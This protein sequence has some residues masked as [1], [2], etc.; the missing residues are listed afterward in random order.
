MK[1]RLLVTG[2]AGEIGQ[3]IRPFL[4][5][6][7]IL[8][9]YDRRPA[10]G[11]SETFTG[12]ICDYST[13]TNAMKEV[14]AVLHLAYPTD[15][16]FD[17]WETIRT[18]GLDGTHNVFEAAIM[19]GVNKIIYAST[20]KI[21]RWDRGDKG[22]YATHNQPTPLEMYAG[23]KL[24][25]E[26]LALTYTTLKPELDI[27][28]LRIAVFRRLPLITDNRSDIDHVGWCHPEDLAQLV[29]KCITSTGLGFQVFYAV[30]QAG[31]RRW[32]I[33]NARRRLGYQPQHNAHDYFVSDHLEELPFT[34]NQRTLMRA[35]LLESKTARQKLW[36]RWSATLNQRLD[37][38][39]HQAIYDLLPMAYQAVDA[40]YATAPVEER[41]LLE[42]M[43]GVLKQAWYQA[44]LHLE[45]VGKLV[46]C[47]Q[48]H[49]ISPIFLD[50][51]A[52][53][54]LLY[55]GEQLRKV[56]SITMIVNPDEQVQTASLLT[57]FGWKAVPNNP[58]P[59]IQQFEQGLLH[60]TLRKNLAP[61]FDLPWSIIQ[62]H[63]SQVDN[64]SLPDL[65]L[66]FLL[67]CWQAVH[68]WK[69]PALL[70]VADGSRLLQ[71]ERAP[72]SAQVLLGLARAANVRS[73]LF[74][75]LHLLKRL[76]GL[77]SAANL[78]SQL[79]SLPLSPTERLLAWLIASCQAHRV[80][81]RLRHALLLDGIGL[82]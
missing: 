53:Y 46:Q 65:N 27:A 60:L 12:D 5:Q 63:T 49:N 9:A 17:S 21:N 16:E 31:A 57:D 73:G 70:G 24:M 1:K 13:L 34:R 41:F 35:T 44:Q 2:A 10:F 28:C 26:N 61:W 8:R 3:A 72:L 6:N 48:D 67:S 19:N 77:R 22:P 75:G 37:I 50:D 18:T 78:N 36:K 42:R 81:R 20:I 43:A 30:S 74:F 11:Y 56:R 64:I 23:G 76:L 15:G 62:A 55:K 14:D 68:G 69:A 80:P 79:L 7:Y 66:F 59:A 47:L 82:R 25:A 71:L 58:S 29:I 45:M 40:D 32:D 4:D 33:R 38:P 52:A 54:K 51:L 39:E